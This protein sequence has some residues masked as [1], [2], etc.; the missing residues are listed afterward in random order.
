[1]LLPIVRPSVYTKPVQREI[2]ASRCQLTGV[3]ALPHPCLPEQ[4]GVRQ[5]GCG[6][7]IRPPSLLCSRYPPARAARARCRHLGSNNG[8]YRPYCHNQTFTLVS[9]MLL[10][11]IRTSN[12][13][14]RIVDVKRQT[15]DASPLS[16][17]SRAL[18]PA[19]V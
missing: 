13:T 17:K 7:R 10:G 14:D 2:F 15:Q 4:D 12:P 16:T 18:T 11:I 1:M 3:R 8:E 9:I 6:G 5:T 19:D